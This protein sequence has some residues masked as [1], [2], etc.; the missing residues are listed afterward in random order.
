[1]SLD[2]LRNRFTGIT[3]IMDLDL[4]VPKYEVIAKLEQAAPKA[5]NNLEVSAK[6]NA[7]GGRKNQIAKIRSG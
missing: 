6:T 1:M 7:F 3:I 5:T 4:S 2:G